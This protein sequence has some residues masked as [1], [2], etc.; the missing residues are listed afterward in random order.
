MGADVAVMQKGLTA[1]FDAVKGVAVTALIATGG[2]VTTDFIFKQIGPTLKLEANSLE[3]N[4]AKAVTAIA[5]GL[6][7][8]KFLKKP[9]LGAAFAIGGVMFALYNIINKELKL[10][11]AGLGYVSAER[12]GFKP[13][14]LA[15]GASS[16]RRASVFQPMQ[17]PAMGYGAY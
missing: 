10:N 15:L 9:Q 6:V 11:T 16:I 3:E 4:L 8:G 7:I 17:A 5:G 13:A 14:P 2:A 1:S 12:L